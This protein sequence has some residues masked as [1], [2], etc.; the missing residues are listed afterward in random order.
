MKKILFIFSLL[1]FVSSCK[2]S[3]NVT[4]TS[5]VVPNIKS[6][7]LDRIVK[8]NDFNI[9][10]FSS[11]IRVLFNKQSFTANLRIKKDSVIWISMTGPFGIEGA[12]VKI[13]KDNFQM[14]NRLNGTYYNEPLSFIENYLPLKVDF[15]MLEQLILGNF[16]EKEIKKQKIETKGQNYIVKGRVEGFDVL[17]FL[18]P[19]GKLENIAIENNLGAQTVD[20]D[21]KQYEKFDN[22]DFSVRREF[23]IKDNLDENIIDLKFY[24]MNTGA[25]L[26]PFK[27]PSSYLK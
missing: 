5:K 21:Y 26:F 23:L 19:N 10:Y 18:M 17:Y 27:V 13:T 25:V 6:K 12:R 15:E 7:K 22:Q 20:V 3:E 4:S 1:I 11:K 24:K 8:Q 16:I 9:D 14:I 2:T